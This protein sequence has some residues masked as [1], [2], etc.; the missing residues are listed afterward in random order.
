M[1]K[2]FLFL[3]VTTFIAQAKTTKF[4]QKKIERK[5]QQQTIP[6]NSKCNGSLLEVLTKLGSKNKWEKQAPTKTGVEVFRTPTSEF[7]HWLE[8]VIDADGLPSVFSIKKSI[9][10]SHEFNSTCQDKLGLKP[11]MDF[12]LRTSDKSKSTWFGDADLK[13]LMLK[14]NEGLIYVWSPEMTYSAQYYKYFRDV[15]KKLN[16]TFTP[17]LDPRSQ[18]LDVEKAI[19]NFGIAPTDVKLNSV[20]LYMRNLTVHYPTTLIYKDGQLSNLPIVGVMPKEDLEAA[21]RRSL[22]DLM[23]GSN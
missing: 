13:K 19:S 14:S 2:I 4:V 9:V 5:P 17:I 1:K 12:S 11:G 23:S 8:I 10:M 22:L 7:G 6:F 3:M 20:E 21:V 18:I 16:L 15:A